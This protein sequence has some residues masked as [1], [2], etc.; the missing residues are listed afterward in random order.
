MRCGLHDE[1]AGVAYLLQYALR[2]SAEA[3]IWVEDTGRWF[4][5]PWS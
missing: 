2:A 3:L 1:G 4:A 5:G